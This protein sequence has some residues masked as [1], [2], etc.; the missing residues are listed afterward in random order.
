MPVNGG[1]DSKRARLHVLA[2]ACTA[3]ADAGTSCSAADCDADAAAI[4]FLDEQ[5]LRGVD[6]VNMDVRQEYRQVSSDSSMPDVCLLHRM[7]MPAAGV[8]VA[9]GPAVRR[10]CNGALGRCS[11][12][13]VLLGCGM[14]TRP[15]R[16]GWPRGTLLFLLAPGEVHAAAERALRGV[17]AAVPSGCLL[18][19]VPIN[20][21]VC[22]SP[23]EDWRFSA[24]RTVHGKR[25]TS[26]IESCVQGD[27]DDFGV[28]LE[29]AGYRGDRLSIWGL[30]VRLH[31]TALRAAC[32]VF[33]S[34]G[35]PTIKVSSLVRCPRPDLT[36]RVARMQGLTHLG[37]RPQQ[38]STLLAHAANMA[39][40]YSLFVGQLPPASEAQANEWLAQ[41]GLLGQLV[42]PAA[43]HGTQP[44]AP[45]AGDGSATGSTGVALRHRVA[46]SEAVP[47][48]FSGQQ[49]RLSLPQMRL[50]NSH[51]LAG[52]DTNEDFEGNFS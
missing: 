30:Q 13:V 9:A 38:V 10:G 46:E 14:D 25:C 16:L 2:C 45:A 12:Q 11:T 6:I 48:L 18:R 17:G 27:V 41:A 29:A 21:E 47:R 22:G 7:S 3:Q 23:P 50:Y 15:F 5:L 39:A 49:Q 32:A 37:L 42:D 1:T 34:R 26:S 31:A 51:V 4:A 33:R 35:L 24:G 19:R 36:L 43:E 20:L 28:T 40:L 8:W 52:E 44:S